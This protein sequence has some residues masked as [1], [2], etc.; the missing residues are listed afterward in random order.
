MKGRQKFSGTWEVGAG[1]EKAP[2][3]SG[4]GTRDFKCVDAEQNS[5]DFFRFNCGFLHNEAEQIVFRFLEDSGDSVFHVIITPETIALFKGDK[6]EMQ[7][8]LK[9]FE[10]GYN[11][12]QIESQPGH[13]RVLVDSNLLGIVLKEKEAAS[14]YIV[15]VETKGPGPAHFEQIRFR[16][17][18]EKEV[19][20]PK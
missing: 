13:W 4:A 9:K 12:F 8:E 10:A 5:L 2:V 7:I 16:K 15:R 3:L 14:T 18:M 20:Q 19:E 1:I 17:F 11:R 6:Q